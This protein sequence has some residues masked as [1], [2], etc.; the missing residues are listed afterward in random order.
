ME[1][2]QSSRRSAMS[3]EERRRASRSLTENGLAAEPEFVFADH[4]RLA[5]LSSDAVGGESG[6]GHRRL[7]GF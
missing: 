6:G 5:D 7:G 1:D 2:S 3:A 4:G